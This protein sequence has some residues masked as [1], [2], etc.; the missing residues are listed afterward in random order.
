MKR[1][2][3][4]L[5]IILTFSAGCASLIPGPTPP[6][7]TPTEKE[8]AMFNVDVS[9]VENRIRFLKNFI[10][11]KDLSDS[12]RNTALALLSAYR[13]LKKTAPGPV[14]GKECDTLAQS[15]FRSMSL[16]ENTY[17]KKIGKVSDDGNS[18]ANFIQR[19]NEIL[20]LYLDENYKGVI[21]R[22]LALR[23]SF[24]DGLTP[25]IGI[26]F[27]TSLAKDGMLE[28]A[29]EVGMEVAGKIESTQDMVKL[30]GDIIEWQLAL[31]QPSQ[32]TQTLERIFHTRDDRAAMINDLSNR[33]EQTP[34]EPDQ[35]FRSMFQTAESP[36]PQEAQPHMVSLQEKVDALAR[37]YEFA[38]AR[39]L[40]LKEKNA[41][42]EGPETEVI[43]RALNNIEEAETTYEESARIKETYLKETYEIAR[44]L[45]EREDYKGAINKLKEIERIQT[46]DAASIDLKN[47]AFEG[48]IN[49]ERNRAAEIFLEAKKTKD[50]EKKKELF[51]ASCKI[52]R[53]LVSDYPKSPLIPKLMSHIKIVQG[54]I[55][56]LKRQSRSFKF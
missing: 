27:A 7:H 26:A 14:T 39:R 50:L 2:H 48:L 29:V 15:L 23:T 49:L 16:M 42:E 45:Y 31:G 36:A 54:E 3:I 22:T 4:F 34:R 40:L 19:K 38:E 35:P 33:I 8:R 21:Q 9:H 24:P 18:F 41:R 11:N 46:L 6:V 12:D 55:D 30:R 10:K 53:T 56:K 51:E 1:T 43:D 25:E 5:F 44:K 17:F 52:L 13:L 20:G 28:E 32:A 47:R 37:N